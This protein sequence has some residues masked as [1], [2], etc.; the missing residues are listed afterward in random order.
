M[1]TW[2]DALVDRNCLPNPFAKTTEAEET[3]G[4]EKGR[5]ECMK[6]E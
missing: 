6:E 5:G 4:V 2:S 1:A 3:V